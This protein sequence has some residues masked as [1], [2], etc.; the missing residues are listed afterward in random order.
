M[1]PPKP[2]P[3][4]GGSCRPAR[5]IIGLLAAGT[6]TIFAAPTA[7]ADTGYQSFQSPSGNISCQ[8]GTFIDSGVVRG[9]AACQVGQHDF[10]APPRPAN[11]DGGWGDS[12]GLTEGRR[13]T[14]QCHT[15]T[16][17]GSSEP[18]LEYGQS[19]SARSITCES[20]QAGV[21]CTDSNSGHSFSISRDGYDVS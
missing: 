6:A 4:P 9:T 15:D 20:T 10:T 3:R 5:F 18:V 16:L 8:L 13:A 7:G 11:C 19:R 21:T 12:V 14:L 17:L 1:P 2:D